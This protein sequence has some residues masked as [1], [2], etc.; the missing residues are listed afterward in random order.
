MPGLLSFLQYIHS[1]FLEIFDKFCMWAL[2]VRV[3]EL[4]PTFQ[5]I[6]TS[7]NFWLRTEHFSEYIIAKLNVYSFPQWLM[8]VFYCFLANGLHLTC[9]TCP[10]L[11]ALT[12]V[13]AEIFWFL[14]L[15]FSLAS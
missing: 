3:C 15:R 11:C 8:V 14:F 6:C 13:C 7:Q 9:R 5:F 2:R 1:S 12:D 10:R 4:D